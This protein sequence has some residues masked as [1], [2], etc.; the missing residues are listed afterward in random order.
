VVR[1]LRLDQKIGSGVP[2]SLKRMA[3]VLNTDVTLFQEF[4]GRFSKYGDKRL[5][6]FADDTPVSERQRNLRR[7]SQ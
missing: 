7:P 6:L 5:T 3:N 2:M 1:L 4:C